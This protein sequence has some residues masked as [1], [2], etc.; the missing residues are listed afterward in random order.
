MRIKSYFA[1]TVE[2]AIDK[3]R[4]DLGSEAM[5][6]NSKKTESDLRALGA[7][8]VVFAVPPEAERVI[9]MQPTKL[10]PKAAPQPG[11]SALPSGNMSH[12]LV[13]EL[14]ELRKQIETVKRSVDRRPTAPFNGAV[15][16][17]P[18]GY[19]L[20]ARLTGADLSEELALEL[21]TAIEIRRG[22][23]GVA[24]SIEAG[25]RAECEQ[26]L[27]FAPALRSTPGAVLLV[28]PA[29]AGKTTTLIKLALRYGLRPNLPIQLLS[30]DTLR[31]G[32]WEQLDSYARIASIP[33]RPIHTPTALSQAFAEAG[34]KKLF[35]IDSPG[36]SP[37]DVA[38]GRH[39][40]AGLA[41]HRDFVEVH[42]V[43]SAAV[44]P[45]IQ[46][47][48]IERFAPFAPAKL[49]FTH[50]DEVE[51]P[52]PLLETALRAGLPISFL[53]KGQQ[54][55]EDIEEATLDLLLSSL[56]SG[57]SSSLVSRTPSS[58]PLQALL[59]SSSAK[60][61]RIASAA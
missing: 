33:C 22:R 55:P 4:R 13:H 43:L 7:Y 18:D 31:I 28:G 61:R 34:Q 16:L 36:F 20:V 15:A 21:A 49:I 56:G 37:A 26:R 25:L 47:A 38:Q 14:S 41:A 54:V 29:G 58:S 45:R 24:L 59:A 17:S 52:G 53:A 48:N 6:M 10:L 12:D 44:L 40:A 8:E 46:L 57:S 30:L 1:A 19:E 11:I 23:D 42:L 27:R 60:S 9:E 35:L 2:E 51:N 3:A 39:L 32:G 5:L 50:L